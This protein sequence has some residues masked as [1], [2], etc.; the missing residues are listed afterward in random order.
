MIKKFSLLS[1][2]ILFAIVLLCLTGS[3]LFLLLQRAFDQSLAEQELRDLRYEAQLDTQQIRE[4]IAVLKQDVAYLSA[5]LQG[6][7]FSPKALAQFMQQKIN[8]SDLHI[9]RP[10]AQDVLHY[11]WQ[12]SGQGV[13]LNQQ[14]KQ[15]LALQDGAKKGVSLHL[16]QHGSR[17][18]LHATQFFVI[19][20]TKIPGTVRLSLDLQHVFELIKP[21]E[22]LAVV[23]DL[24]NQ[25][26]QPLMTSRQQATKRIW[27]PHK[28]SRQQHIEAVH[29]DGQAY[30]SVSQALFLDDAQAKALVVVVS[31]PKFSLLDRTQWL[32]QR[33]LVIIIVVLA[34]TALIAIV[35]A[36]RLTSVLSQLTTNAQRVSEGEEAADLPIARTDELGILARAFTQMLETIRHRTMAL[37]H[38]NKELQQFAF[39]ASHDL[40]EPLRKVQT[41]GSFLQTAMVDKIT[42]ENAHFLQKMIAAVERM[43]HLVDSLLAYASVSRRRLLISQVDLEQVWK[44]V[45]N[46]LSL[47]IEETRAVITKESILPVLAGDATQ[48]QQLLQNLL[49]NAL[50]YHKPGQSPQITMHCRV[51]IQFEKLKTQQCELIIS[52]QGIGFPEVYVEK[53][54]TMFQRLHEDDER[55]VGIGL[56]LCDRIVQRHQGQ[57]SIETKEGEGTKVRIVLPLQQPVKGDPY[58]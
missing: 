16:E 7:Q 36:R 40:K 12:R 47:L 58:D 43:R 22:Q 8:Y 56:A 26:G 31:A 42:G 44:M 52:D 33:S 48:L 23:V 35:F 11:H 10:T 51:I 17:W 1:K 18:Q 29:I 28:L 38:S 30:F 46:D 54:L 50:R 39:V 25:Q 14:H 41:F 55:G 37:E 45:T 27:R 20:D 9:T 32:E 5:I 53:A 2:I 34:L 4:Q 57:I 3:G 19:D 49:T 13:V 24:L 15:A 6:A 21:G